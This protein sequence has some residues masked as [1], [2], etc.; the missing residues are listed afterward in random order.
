M[1]LCRY[2]GALPRLRA[3]RRRSQTYGM[4]FSE[5]DDATSKPT[6][7]GSLTAA[8]ADRMAAADCNAPVVAPAFLTAGGLPTR[9]IAIALT[10]SQMVRH[11]IAS[12]GSGVVCCGS[13]ARRLHCRGHFLSRFASR[14]AGSGCGTAHANSRLWARRHVAACAARAAAWVRA[15]EVVQPSAAKLAGKV[16][17]PPSDGCRSGWRLRHLRSVDCYSTGASTRRMGACQRTMSPGRHA[18]ESVSPTTMLRDH[19]AA[20]A[21]AVERF[22]R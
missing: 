20:L 9:R 14:A 13:A 12:A 7:A 15:G 22:H 5:M 16:V 1:S 2:R 6:G 18:G 19:R 11:P 10:R 3:G 17:L 8:A 4:T 21:A